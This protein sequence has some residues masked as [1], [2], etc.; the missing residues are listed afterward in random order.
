MQEI[1]FPHILLHRDAGFCIFHAFVK[2]HEFNQVCIFLK[3]SDFEKKPGS[4]LN[5][6]DYMSDF[7]SIVLH[8]VKFRL[9]K[10]TTCQNLI[11]KF[12]LIL[13]SISI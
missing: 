12:P 13:K 8:F 9:E 1:M 4:V 11:W 7:N 3:Q 5:L 2:K 6:E 10:F